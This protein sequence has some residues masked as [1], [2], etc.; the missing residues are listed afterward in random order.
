[1]S[2][3]SIKIQVLTNNE[4]V[5]IPIS[6]KII[7]INQNHCSLT[8]VECTLFAKCQG[9]ELLKILTN[10]LQQQFSTVTTFS[11]TSLTK[12]SHCVLSVF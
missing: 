10:D 6:I 9:I 3:W 4:P 5:S 2:L 1:M 12:F 8:T 11:T 7:I